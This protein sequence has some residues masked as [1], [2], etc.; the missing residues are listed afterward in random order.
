MQIIPL[1]QQAT[2]SE[3]LEVLA[4][5]RRIAMVPHQTAQQFMQTSRSFRTVQQIPL[6]VVLIA[7]TSGIPR[8]HPDFLRAR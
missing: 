2:A 7:P 3:P 6:T 8:K 1:F 4:L 5:S